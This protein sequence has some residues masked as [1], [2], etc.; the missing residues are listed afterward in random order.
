MEE[1]FA[2]L[3]GTWT[4]VKM[5][6]NGESRLEKSDKAKLIIKAGKVTLDANYAPKDAL[7]LSKVLDPSKRPKTITLPYQEKITFYGIYELE[8]DELRLCAEIVETTNE[9]DPEARRPKGFDSKK[10]LLLVFKRENQ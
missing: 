10:G 3:E 6:L 4:L 1:E 8:A 9:K 2:K 7:E 5:E